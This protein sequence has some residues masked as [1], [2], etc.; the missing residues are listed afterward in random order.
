MPSCRSREIKG[1][2]AK[3]K[4]ID[5][6]VFHIPHPYY[7]SQHHGGYLKACIWL[8]LDQESTARIA[9]VGHPGIEIQKGETELSLEMVEEIMIE[10]VIDVTIGTVAMTVI[11]IGIMTVPADMIQGEES[12][13]APGSAAG[14]TE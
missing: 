2:R 3:L 14:I 8:F 9:T 10:I 7:F 6:M 12:V 11:G 1:G 13:H 4:M 5:G